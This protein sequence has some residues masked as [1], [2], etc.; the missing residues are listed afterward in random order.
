MGNIKGLG[1]GLDSLLPGTEK[2]LEENN[3]FFLCPVNSIQPNPHQPRKEF[4]PTG[5]DELADSIKAKGIIQPLIVYKD[6][7]GKKE[8]FLIAG[9]RRWRAAKIAGLKKV[10]AII[11]D[12][13]SDDLLELALIENIQRQDLN[14]IEEAEAY[15]KLV[16]DFNLTQNEIAKRVGKMRTTITNML[17]LLK[18]PDFV[19]K[20]IQGGTLSMGH[21]RCLLS[22][23][24]D[25]KLLNKIRTEILSKGLSV[26]QT[27]NM[28]KGHKKNDASQKE[29]PKKLS[30][31]IAQPYSRA[32]TNALNTY[33]GTKAKIIQRG[34]Q[35]KIEVEYSS[36]EDLERILKLIIKE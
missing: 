35:G 5:L 13:S 25:A 11:K 21:A 34:S 17:R 8:F 2:D 19:K 31:T 20:D 12:V 33:L 1:R 7:S 24:D 18:L 15:S 9:E 10:P 23:I 14:P 28:V 26:R 32:L 36:P 16:N 22:V 27:E 4:D 6:G 29:H 3:G 30:G